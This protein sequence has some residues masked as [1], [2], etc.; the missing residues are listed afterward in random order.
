MP[1]AVGQTV[2]HPHHG[3]AVVDDVEHRD[4][5]GE[6]VEYL[7]LS[8]PDLDLVLRVPAETCEDVGLREC[9]NQDQLSLVL[10][11]LG[12]EG[13]PPTGHWSRRLK[14]N[15]QRLRSGEPEEVARVLRDLTIKDEGKGLS[16]AERRL[17]DQARRMLLGEVAAV[18]DGDID[19]ADAMLDKAL[20]LEP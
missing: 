19:D 6:Q 20:G 17:R 18:I 14:A 11:V 13:T 3:A 1:F 2:V 8:A 10:D 15:Q 4:L 5:N 7:V 9:I 16:P 12:A